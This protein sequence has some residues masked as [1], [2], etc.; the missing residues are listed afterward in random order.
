MIKTAKRPLYYHRNAE[1]CRN[2]TIA[3][4][5][6]KNSNE[7][8]FAQ[9][10]RDSAK[11]MRALFLHSL[12]QN[13]DFRSTFR[14]FGYRIKKITDMKDEKTPIAPLKSEEEEQLRYWA[15]AVYAAA[16]VASKLHLTQM[17]KGGNDYFSSHLLKVGCAGRTWKQQI[18]GFL[19]D[20][21]E[22][23]GHD[24]D[25][26]LDMVKNQLHEWAGHP[27]D[28]SWMTSLSEEAMPATDGIIHFPTENDWKEIADAL[29]L[30]NHHTAPNR[31]EYI[32]RFGANLL[33]LQVKM[34]D[35]RNNMDLSR[36]SN[37][38]AKDFDRLERYKREFEVLQ[39]M[40]HD[41]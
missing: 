41:H 38:T 40:L 18:V 16:F 28:K 29:R 10:C 37:P 7:F 30:L 33:A 32:K 2:I 13:L 25:T 9:L 3:T 27:E 5:N 21:E 22:D 20:A 11:P 26:V 12:L 35:M 15:A 6:Q 34:N 31:E 8:G 19:H 17:D 4:P 36:I 24:V 14:N 1:T 39:Q 23:T